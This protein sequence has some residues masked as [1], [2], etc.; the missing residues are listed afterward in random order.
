M[1]SWENLPN[2]TEYILLGY[3]LYLCAARISEGLS[4]KVCDIVFKE[5]NSSYIKIK[6]LKQK[7]KTRIRSI[8]VSN[9]AVIAKLKESITMRK[10]KNS[11][12]L[13]NF[14]RQWFNAQL[15]NVS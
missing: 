11:D 3:I 7:G 12:R 6:T 10:L 15:F 4:I 5:E 2:C 13:F 14:T 1:A 8:P 9:V